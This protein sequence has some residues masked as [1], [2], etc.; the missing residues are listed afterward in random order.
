MSYREEK[1]K[2]QEKAINSSKEIMHVGHTATSRE[3]PGRMHMKMNK[4][5]GG[6]K[7]RDMFHC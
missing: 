3:D 1:K 2:K 5:E 4:E 6:N 7:E